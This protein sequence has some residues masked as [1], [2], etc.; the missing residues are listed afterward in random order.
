MLDFFKYTFFAL[1]SL[2]FSSLQ[3]GLTVTDIADRQVTLEAPVERFVISEGRYVTTLA[4]LQPE[5]PLAGVVGMMSPIAYSNPTLEAYLFKHYPEARDIPLFG[6]QDENSVSVEKIIDLAP[7]LAIFGIQDHGPGTR[8]AELIG[9]LTQAGIPIVFI[10]F[11]L[12]PLNHTLPSLKLLGQVLGKSKQVSAYID[13]YREKREKIRKIGERQEENPSVFLQA[14]AGRMGCCRAM[15]DGMLGPFISV[16]GGKNIADAVAA[17]PTSMHTAEFLLTQ[18]PDVWVGTASGTFDEYRSGKSP[19]A[20]GP[21]VSALDAKKS[22]QRFLQQPTFTPLSAVTEGRAHSLWHDLYNSPLNI[23]ALE[24]LAV[25]IHPKAFADL[26][27]KQTIDDIHQRFLQ[28]PVMG[29][30]AAS[31]S[32]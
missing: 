19:V 31:L 23:I 13:F 9:Q 11:R 4:L 20:A 30:Y 29:A 28:W 12:D 3:A 15:A 1:L 25:W 18:N 17:G 14:H 27:V 32:E 22:L 8:N 5:A 6:R 7:Q 10:D 24:A 16:V 21:G 26:D 2:A